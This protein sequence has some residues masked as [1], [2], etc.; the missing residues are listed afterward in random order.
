[1]IFNYGL[2]NKILK[3]IVF[4]VKKYQKISHGLIMRFVKKSFLKYKIF[5]MTFEH[6]FIDF[7]N[8]IK[9]KIA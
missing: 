9:Y 5:M 1:V 3:E 6:Y 8:S 7:K 4:I 2:I